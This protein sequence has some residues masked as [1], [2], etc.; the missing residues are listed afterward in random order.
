MY[1]KLLKP[2]QSF[3]ITLYITTTVGIKAAA[4]SFLS[5]QLRLGPK[6]YRTLEFQLP[7][8]HPINNYYRVEFNYDADATLTLPNDA[9]SQHLSV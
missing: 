7:F 1:D 8:P 2:G 5:I 6:I 4:A 9:T 3:R